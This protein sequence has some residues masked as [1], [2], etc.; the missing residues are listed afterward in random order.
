MADKPE[1]IFVDESGDPG[2]P[3][4]F[5]SNPIYILVAL[6]L[7][8]A[9]LR[10]AQRHLT[11]FRYHHG[12]SKELKD[13]GALLKDRFTPVTRALLGFFAELVPTGEASATGHWLEKSKYVGNGG[14]YLSGPGASTTK[15]RHFQLRLLLERHKAQ[16][17]WGPQVDLVLDRWSMNDEQRSD[18]ENYLKGNWAL[19]PIRDITFV[20]SRYVDMVQVADLFTRLIRRVVEGEADDE[21]VEMCGRLID[22]HEV[23]KGLY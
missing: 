23:E 14:P 4:K 13:T 5:G 20:D 18:V 12:V 19:R 6:H 8:D 11:A 21:Q 16:R 1:F 3:A 15:F 17:P 2:D 22:L 7:S 9:A 10:Q